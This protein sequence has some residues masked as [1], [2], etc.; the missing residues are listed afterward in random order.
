MKAFCVRGCA[1]LPGRFHC[2][3]ASFARV[4]LICGS[5]SLQEGFSRAGLPVCWH[6]VT[7]PVAA[8]NFIVVAV[9]VRVVVFALVTADAL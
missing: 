5:T 7:V 4:C 6:V 1:C 8:D 9:V 2:M 3:K